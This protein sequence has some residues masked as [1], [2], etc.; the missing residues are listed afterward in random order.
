VPP[1][2]GHVD[3][4]IILLRAH[5]QECIGDLQPLPFLVS[6]P[7]VRAQGLRLR[8]DGI[9]P[10]A[11]KFRPGLIKGGLGGGAGMNVHRRQAVALPQ[12]AKEGVWCFCPPCLA[13]IRPLAD[14]AGKWLGRLGYIPHQLL[15]PIGH[16][17][18]PFFMRSLQ[19]GRACP[20]LDTGP[21]G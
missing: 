8:G 21:H 2:N 10:G 19:R 11:G 12:Q 5:D 13:G 7:A 17:R 3:G 15:P 1:N 9:E 16:L 6:E 4:E 20:H 18:V 14:V